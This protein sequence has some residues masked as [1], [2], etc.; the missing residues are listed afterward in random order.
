MTVLFATLYKLLLKVVHYRLILLTHGFAQRICITFCKVCNPLRQ[1]HHLFLVYRNPV[2]R[3]EHLFH[4]RKV[5]L[6]LLKSMFA[7]DKIGYIIHRSRP[8]KSIHG[9]QV[10]KYRRL[11]LPEPFSH[12]VAFKLE[13]ANRISPAEQL[14]C[15]FVIQRNRLDINLQ[16]S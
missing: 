5:V 3:R 6:N 4:H 13:G 1:E 9:Y 15:S 16:P 10:L 11:Q 14:V 12:T 2:C 7:T 8:V